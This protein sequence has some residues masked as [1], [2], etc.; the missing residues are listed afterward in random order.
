M[1][2]GDAGI[3]DAAAARSQKEVGFT[4][5]ALRNRLSCCMH[6]VL[7][8]FADDKKPCSRTVKPCVQLR[9]CHR[10]TSSDMYLQ[11]MV[12][13]V[14]LRK[15]NDDTFDNIHKHHAV[16]A[17]TAHKYHIHL[18]MRVL[19]PKLPDAVTATSIA[20]GAAVASTFSSS[21]TCSSVTVTSLT[22]TSS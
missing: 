14:G 16:T 7:T 3:G 20:G 9:P 10:H 12:Y 21:A 17:G 22:P 5:E 4:S 2:E 11:L 6:Q 15:S 19:K 8:L 1:L 18:G 13:T